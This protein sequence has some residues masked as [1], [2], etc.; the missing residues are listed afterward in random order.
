MPEA[1]SPIAARFHAAPSSTPKHRRL[2][3]AII[4]AVEAGE[5]E[6]GAK[7]AGER[8][9]SETLGLSL[10]TT[11][12]ALGALMGEGFLERRQ[13]HGTFVGRARKSVA[14]TWHYRFVPPG[15]GDELPVYSAILERRLETA[16]GPWSEVLGTDPKGYVVVRRRADIG[17]AFFCA[18]R[19][20]LP[21]SRFA[22]LLRVA[23]RRLTD[24]NLKEVLAADFGAPTLQSDGLAFLRPC[25]DDDAGVIGIAPGTPCLHMHI[26][27]RSVGRV[28]ITFQLMVVPP[29]DHALKLDFNPPR[30]R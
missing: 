23:E 22:R 14:G 8:E 17:G 19:L 28:P 2:R 25:G 3:E 30:E 16:Q 9:L 26:T 5:L 7:L 11:Q 12:K 15:G 6:V 13:G 27:G 18:S 4:G 1:P 29:T 21:A 20:Y 10:G 24:T